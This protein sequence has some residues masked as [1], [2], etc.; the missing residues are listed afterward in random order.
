MLTSTNIPELGM[1]M[2]SDAR[3]M[4]RGGHETR[5][6]RCGGAELVERSLMWALNTST[7][8]ACSA[9]MM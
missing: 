8:A 6:E 3:I 9:R 7:G 2:P 1:M 4:R 5:E